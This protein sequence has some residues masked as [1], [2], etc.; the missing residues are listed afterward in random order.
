MRLSLGRDSANFSRMSPIATVDAPFNKSELENIPVIAA[1]DVA[2]YLNS[3]IKHGTEMS[4]LFG[5]IKTVL[6]G[7]RLRI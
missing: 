2:L 4:D 7:S 5:R 3:V 1:D 6:A